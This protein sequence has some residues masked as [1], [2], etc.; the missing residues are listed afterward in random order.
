M[1]LPAKIQEAPLRGFLSSQGVGL[2]GF[3]WAMERVIE[4]R[5]GQESSLQN[6]SPLKKR[7]LLSEHLLGD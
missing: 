2:L 6:K 4:N 1:V 5:H 7:A 3:Y